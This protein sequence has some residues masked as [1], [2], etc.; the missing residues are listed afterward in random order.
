MSRWSLKPEAPH[1]AATT[2]GQP[3]EDPVPA[4]PCIV[5]EGQRGAVGTVDVGLLSAERMKEQ[6]KGQQAGR[7][8]HKP[9][10]TGE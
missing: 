10:L 4:D 9:S 3:W 2:P 5:A 1:G 7:Q 8:A 6:V